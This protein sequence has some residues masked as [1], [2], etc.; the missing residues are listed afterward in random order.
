MIVQL[1]RLTVNSSTRDCSQD[2]RLLGRHA[3][4]Q[5]LQGEAWPH[6]SPRV[7]AARVTWC[8][9]MG[10]HSGCLIVILAAAGRGWTA[11]FA[12]YPGVEAASEV[13]CRAAASDVVVQPLPWCHRHH[14]RQALSAMAVWAVAASAAHSL[15]GGQAWHGSRPATGS[16]GE[17]NVTSVQTRASSCSDHSQWSL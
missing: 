2:T 16:S 11:I 6:V 12:V 8:G 14:H 5:L 17:G 4:Y 3:Q 7:P 1:C 9:R 10:G 15:T 13:W